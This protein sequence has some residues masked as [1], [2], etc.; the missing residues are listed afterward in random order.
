MTE[1]AKQTIRI[2]GFPSVDPLLKL[3]QAEA[4]RKGVGLATVARIR[5][6][7]SYRREQEQEG[8]KK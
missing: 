4:K 2:E 7:E 3:I 6:M 1:E 5:L 8:R